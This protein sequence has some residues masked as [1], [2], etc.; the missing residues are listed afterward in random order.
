MVE[1]RA[2]QEANKNLTQEEKQ[3]LRRAKKAEKAAKVQKKG[4][5]LNGAKGAANANAKGAAKGINSTAATTAAT[6][7]T[8][9]AKTAPTKPAQ[10]R[11]S[12]QLLYRFFSNSFFSPTTSRDLAVPPFNPTDPAGQVGLHPLFLQLGLLMGNREVCGANRRAEYLLRAMKQLLRDV[13][14]LP[15]ES[16]LD[17]ASAV[18]F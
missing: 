17:V 12:Q 16:A 7:A 10:R 5:E 2:Q 15:E 8:A 4:E 14:A 6:T 18:A 13:P 9:T 1:I 11:E 3:A